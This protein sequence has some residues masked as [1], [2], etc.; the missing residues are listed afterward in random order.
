MHH[1]L[2]SE[3]IAMEDA[4]SSEDD[5]IVVT[6]D[7]DLKDVIPIFFEDLDASM[8]IINEALGKG[9]LETAGKYGHNIIVA[10]SYGFD[11]ISKAGRAIEKVALKGDTNSARA[12]FESIVRLRKRV[13]ISFG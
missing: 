1:A 13:E 10:G 4:N 8:K 5:K 9:D 12:E 7:S 2:A 6:V 11:L 3:I